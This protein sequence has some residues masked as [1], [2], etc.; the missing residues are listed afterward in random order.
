MTGNFLAGVRGFWRGVRLCAHPRL[1]LYVAAP[2]V[3]ASALFVLLVNWAVEA[4]QRLSSALIAWL[5]DWLDWLHWLLWPAAIIIAVLFLVYGFV[6][7][8]NLIAAPFNGLLAERAEQLL[9]GST[10]S[11]VPWM[12]LLRELPTLLLNEV[13]KIGYFLRFAL[14]L[15]LLTLIPG[16]NLAAGP[17]WLLLGSWMLALEYL[18]YPLGNH[19]L[20]FPAVR[21]YARLHRGRALGFGAVALLASTVPLINLLVMPAAVIGATVLVVEAGRDANAA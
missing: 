12:R 6:F 8:C 7:L 13:R 5:P 19:Q 17:L 1:R 15:L 14:P 3:T 20:G 18:D 4:V 11:D 2:I 16:I 9:A 10:P 21:R